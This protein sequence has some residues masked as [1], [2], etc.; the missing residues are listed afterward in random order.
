MLKIHENSIIEPKVTITSL[1]GSGLPAFLHMK[2]FGQDGWILVSI[3]YA[4]MN[5]ECVSVHT[6]KP[7]KKILSQSLRHHP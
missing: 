1:D 5:L 6:T 2:M 7:K 3:F 4:F